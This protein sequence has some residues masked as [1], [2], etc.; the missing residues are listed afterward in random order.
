[1]WH[2]GLCHCSCHPATKELALLKQPGV[3]P[4]PFQTDQF[5]PPTPPR[6]CSFPIKPESNYLGL[7][8]DQ[9]GLLSSI[10]FKTLWAGRIMTRH[11][12]A[13]PVLGCRGGN[14]PAPPMVGFWGSRGSGGTIRGALM[15]V[16]FP[17]VLWQRV[18]QDCAD[19]FARW[20]AQQQQQHP[21]VQR[22]GGCGATHHGGVLLS[23]PSL[24][25]GIPILETPELLFPTA[26]LIMPA[27]SVSPALPGLWDPLWDALGNTHPI[28]PYKSK[29][30]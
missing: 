17:G 21:M 12:V 18:N 28:T 15:S 7:A 6:K 19:V 4:K 14:H 8:S 13:A 9:K 27:A 3:K 23:V 25:C 30:N 22:A 20:F 5:H 10:V 11:R 29:P 1:M 24:G 26:G 2:H 16:L